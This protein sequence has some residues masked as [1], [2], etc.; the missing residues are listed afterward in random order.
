MAL[1][2]PDP[3]R[4]TAVLIGSST[5]RDPRLG[6]LPGVVNN[7]TDLAG[8][9]ADVEL[10]GLSAR[11]IATL[12]DSA[13]NAEVTERLSQAAA[14]AFDTFFVYY[15]GHGLLARDGDLVL[16]TQT[17]RADLPEYTGL[18]YAF[19]RDIVDRCRAA[20]RIV[21]LDCCFSGRALRAMSDPATAVIGQVDA[22]GVY[23][24]TSA[25]ATSPSVAPPDARHTAFTGGLL[26]IL[27]AGIPGGNEVLTLDDV[28]DHA[29]VAMARRGW[30]RPQRLGTNTIGRLGFLRNRAWRRAPASARTG[31]VADPGQHRHLAEGVR[32]A[33]AVVA[34]ALGPTGRDG[35]DAINDAFPAHAGTSA[36]GTADHR[37]REAGIALVRE[38]MLAMREQY[39]DG[40]TT[41]AVM[42]G[43]FVDGLQTLL[44]SGT[45][46]GRLD[47][48]I[49]GETARL[50]RQ[51]LT[52]ARPASEWADPS[53]PSVDGLSA[54]VR[55]ALGRHEVTDAVVAAARSVG[56]GNVE[57]VAASA[58][59]STATTSTFV[60][61][62]KVLAPNAAAGPI[63]LD[64][65][66]IVA[67]PDGQVDVRALL[68]AAGG[69]SRTAI[70]IIAPRVTTVA[71]RSLLHAFSQ[72]VV[73]CPTAPGF[74]LAALR[75][76]LAPAEGASWSRARRALVLPTAT[77][78][79]RPSVDLELSRN[80]VVLKISGQD[81]LALAVRA[82]AVARS[83]ADAG[84]VP[85][86]GAALRAA[87]Q[88]REP[89]TMQD[90]VTALV[91]AAACEPYRQIQLAGGRHGEETS[92]R[93]AAGT[94]ETT[95]D[96][97][98]T[99]RGALAHAGASAARYLTGISG[100][101]GDS[102]A[103]R[104]LGA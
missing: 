14:G 25:P 78:I 91:H 74:D 70:L 102:G 22:D 4:S 101:A 33:V 1:S 56:A 2:L 21:I 11:H 87:A 95:A 18:P 41:A 53:E 3:A 60:L 85:G 80:R 81:D 36:A 89:G 66:L 99:V 86:A 32:D 69:S 13:D 26:R 50:G 49:G 47:A 31:P 62:S 46:P 76:R 79:D 34:P 29:L 63:S 24:L 92:S 61:D 98:A 55:T 51:L 40:A 8:I 39:G 96:S 35:L 94:V 5:Y 100:F 72:V 104:R 12:L 45:E 42:V 54:A 30:P 103:A 17:A 71:V 77:T 16:G 15:S 58:G 68:A 9:L 7:V 90:P 57:V 59:A 10:L 52:A 27:R 43:V 44:E 82:L 19:V 93:D 48:A 23:V 75:D 83:V 65:P 97:L 20:R 38:T 67:S 28:Y 84:V 37:G 88:A 6:A 64:A 73:V